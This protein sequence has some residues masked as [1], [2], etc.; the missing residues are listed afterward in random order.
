MSVRKS[1]PTFV[2]ELFGFLG[3]TTLHTIGE[4]LEALIRYGE[5]K[6]FEALTGRRFIAQILD[7]FE[8]AEQHEI[9]GISA[10][11]ILDVFWYMVEWT[12]ALSV[13]IEPELVD[14]L[15]LEMIQEGF[16]NAIQT[17][18]GGAFQTL[19]NV[20]RG[21]SP[22]PT[23]YARDIA[24][25]IG[26]IDTKTLALLWAMTGFNYPTLV[27][28]VLRGLHLQ[29][30]EV[31]TDVYNQVLDLIR[32]WND[33]IFTWHRILLA[34]TRSRFAKVCEFVEDA[35]ERAYSV[36]ERV[37]NTHLARINE[38]LDSLEGL[39]QQYDAGLISEEEFKIEARVI[40]LEAKGSKEAY[41]SY[42]QAIQETINKAEE[43]VD[44]YVNQIVEKIPLVYETIA[45]TF[46]KKLST[47][48][49]GFN[50]WLEQMLNVVTEALRGVRA[51]RN[52]TEPVTLSKEFIYVPPT[53]IRSFYA[54][55]S[56]I[57]YDMH[58]VVAPTQIY[59]EEDLFEFTTFI[60]ITKTIAEGYE[61][62]LEF[63][64]EVNVTGTGR[65]YGEEDL[66]EFTVETII[67]K[68]PPSGL[69]P[70]DPLWAPSEG[71]TKVWDFEREEEVTEC[72]NTRVGKYSVFNSVLYIEPE[73]RYHT[74]LTRNSNK[75]CKRMAIAIR[76]ERDKVE[77]RDRTFQFKSEDGNE[78]LW[79][80][81]DIDVNYM[82]EVDVNAGISTTYYGSV[83][84]HVVVI[85]FS[86]RKVT[87]YNANRE[88][89]SEFYLQ[90]AGTNYIGYVISLVARNNEYLNSY[91][92][93]VDWI[94]VKEETVNKFVG[95]E[96]LFGY[97]VNVSVTPPSV[98]YE[99]EEPVFE[100]TIDINVTL[101]SASYEGEEAVIGYTVDI[102][103]TQPS[104]AELDPNDPT[105]APSEG[106]TSVWQFNSE[107][108]LNDFANYGIANAYVENGVLK[109]YD[110]DDGFANRSYDINIRKMV[111]CLK[112]KHISNGT[113]GHPT[114]LIVTVTDGQ[115][116]ASVSLGALDSETL[117]LSDIGTFQNPN[118]FFVVVLDF[119]TY[120]VK[121]YDR[122]KN[123]LIE[124]TMTLYSTTATGTQIQICE[125]HNPGNGD[126]DVEVDWVAVLE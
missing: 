15:L 96:D 122:N 52:I 21:G 39:K 83:G 69:D 59:G 33:Y 54:E 110:T 6:L 22:P 2:G 72:F 77:T 49:E 105:W 91:R 63:T 43:E 73:E 126:S 48:S 31:A 70:N 117:A 27:F 25:E 113:A 35:I 109:F 98:S 13:I 85:D 24:Q 55:E 3:E 103:V 65:A 74:E 81:I 38:F 61:D 118:D 123:V 5:W 58:V 88:K 119:E 120:T 68:V 106:W 14:E 16:T 60:A 32:E 67:S 56:V 124:G 10:K 47:A 76:F 89:V 100:Y 18:V 111:I 71:W 40:Y 87:V 104:G 94:A 101:P 46:S 62:L 116:M 30:D 8:K 12:V 97:T 95:E 17:S 41:D 28:D 80:A 19:L 112:V 90:Y 29:M 42:V 57:E 64:T 9:S 7:L 108:E 115:N 53:P 79:Y 45:E 36:T 1:I 107:E 50:A 51:Y 84:W 4:N 125:D 93:Y 11:G 114:P 34:E 26:N 99:G 86:E 75:F 23:D 82:F 78:R 20:Y 92:V 102:N 121:V 44:T 37:I 66:F